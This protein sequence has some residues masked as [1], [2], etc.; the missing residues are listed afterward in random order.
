MTGTLLRAKTEG[1]HSY[2]LSVDRAY[3]VPI[4]ICLSLTIFGLYSVGATMKEELIAYIVEPDSPG[5]VAKADPKSAQYDPSYSP[6]ADSAGLYYTPTKDPNSTN[7][8][9]QS[10]PYN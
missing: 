8:I 2:L 10:D 4:Y 6:F 7:Y 3:P 1:I 9:P 5:Y